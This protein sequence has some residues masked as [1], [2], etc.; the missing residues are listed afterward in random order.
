M[1]KNVDQGVAVEGTATHHR[2]T[3]SPKEEEKSL[4]IFFC[5]GASISIGQEIRCLP[6]AFF[7]NTCLKMGS[8]IKLSCHFHVG[9]LASSWLL[10]LA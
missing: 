1:G 5:I 6:Y 2:F 8:K 7:F 4:Y 3:K 9:G 10:I